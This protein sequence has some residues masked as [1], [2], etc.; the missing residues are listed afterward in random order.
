MRSLD[1]ITRWT[2]R[3]QSGDFSADSVTI[4]WWGDPANHRRAGTFTGIARFLAGPNERQASAHFVVSGL[5]RKLAC[6]V[7]LDHAAWH[8]G[9]WQ[10]NHRSVGIECRPWDSRTPAA[11]VEAELDAVAYTVAL[12]WHWR[13]KLKGQRLKGHRDWYG[14]ACPGSYYGRL[15][16]IRDRALATYPNIDPDHPGKLTTTTPKDWF[17]MAT[18]NDL[19]RIVREESLRGDHVPAPA[20]APKDPKNPTWTGA[21]V[22]SYTLNIARQSREHA[23]RAEKNSA[24]TL[25]I[26]RDMAKQPGPLTEAQIA[27]AAKRGLQS[28]VVDADVSVEVQGDQ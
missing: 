15:D 10:G 7:D 6:L 13:P 26:V 14:T 22:L 21:N 19:R 18:E 23:I 28:I 5:E 27:E 20:Y 17:T 4:H 24:A 11:E 8:A 25:E 9:V 2:A 1:Y 3:H 16:D 12:I